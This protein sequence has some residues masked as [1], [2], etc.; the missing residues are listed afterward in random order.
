[1]NA[2]NRVAI[3]GSDPVAWLA[4]LALHRAFRHRG[5]Q[6]TVVDTATGGEPRGARWTLPSQRG[7]HAMIGIEEPDLLRATGATY[8]LATE[9]LGFQG[10]GSR[11]L[12]AHGDIG[13]DH[14]G[15]PFYKYLFKEILAGQRAS[16]E[17]YSL[18][19][20]AA[21][22]GRFARPM[23]DSSALA[24]SFTYGFH[25]PEAAYVAYLRDQARRAG[26]V[27]IEAAVVGLDRSEDGRVSALRLATGQSVIADFFIETVDALDDAAE[28]DDW[29]AWLPCNRKAQTMVPPAANPAP[30]TQ[31]AASAAGWTWRVP[32]AKATAVGH[33]YCSDFLDDAAARAALEAR[34]P[35][36]TETPAVTRFRSGRLRKFWS[37]NHLSL[38]AAAMQLEPLAGADLHFAQLGVAMLIELF[39]FDAHGAVEGIEYNRIMSEHADALRD[40]TVAHYRAG[41]ARDGEFWKATRGA[42]LPDT[43]AR[44]LDLFR[45]NGRIDLRDH[46]SFE[47][48]DWAWLLLGAGAVPQ[49]LELQITSRLQ[50][51][52]AEDASA[53]RKQIG[54]IAASMPRH[55]DYVN[56]QLASGRP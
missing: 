10:E 53:L 34:S 37:A 14:G 40:F 12:H 47:E 9:Y 4:A 13:G 45:A 29:S 30:V 50:A 31:I 19:A 48:L 22:L 15:A 41:D 44:K 52:R 24:S 11:F 38:G 36:A 32:L 27:C 51:V 39:P 43:L 54:Q 5:L 18:A 55:I 33:V 23:R 49:A 25:L 26:I 20:V 3:A 21:K 42:D 6:I 35:G 28:R 17:D 7:M 56:H 8:K 46:E 2:V 1:V 16:P